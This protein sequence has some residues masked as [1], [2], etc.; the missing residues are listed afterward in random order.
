ME[1][2]RKRFFEN[3][4]RMARKKKIKLEDIKYCTVYFAASL[5]GKSQ[6]YKQFVRVPVGTKIKQT[7]DMVILQLPWNDM[8]ISISKVILRSEC[9]KRI[10]VYKKQLKISAKMGREPAMGRKLF[11]QQDD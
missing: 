6:V 8:A 11:H 2:I 1:A 7:E 4:H 3:I 10:K 5:D 9:N